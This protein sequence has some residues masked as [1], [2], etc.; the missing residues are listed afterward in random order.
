[1]QAL[2]G[3]VTVLVKVASAPGAREATVNTVVLTEGRSLVTTTSVRVMFPV[4]RT[5]PLYWN[6]PPGNIGA[7]GQFTVTKI[8]GAVRMGQAEVTTLLT[9]VPQML[10]PVAVD[11]LMEEQSA[12]AK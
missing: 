1:M 4:L 11:V 2:A 5:V 8:F 9:S 12:V 10:R 3:T 7:A 6:E